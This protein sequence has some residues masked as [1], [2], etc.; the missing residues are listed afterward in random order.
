MARRRRLIVG[1]WKMYGRL[2]SGL[3]LARDLAEKAQANKPLN[4]DMVLCPPATL[5]WA[6]NE[7]ILGSPLILGGQDC[8]TATHGAYTGD[9]SAAQLADLGCRYVIVGHSERRGA[10]GETNELVA[11]KVQAAQLA[12][13]TAILCI[14]E[15]AEQLAAG[16]TADIIEAQLRASLPDKCKMAHLVVAYEPV[17]AIGSGQQPSPADIIAVNKVIRKTLGEAGETMQILY[18]GSVTPVNAGAILGEIEVD[19]VLVGSASINAD[20]FWAI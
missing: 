3:V 8:H 12:G 17:W 15:T 11:Q 14:G 13:L 6:I 1:N 4:Y 18:G 7:A 19:G 2:T 16:A 9:I 20:G 5:T 10:H